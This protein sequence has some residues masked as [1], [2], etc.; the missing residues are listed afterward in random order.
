MAFKVTWLGHERFE[1]YTLTFEPG[2][3]RYFQSR[4]H[5]PN[6]ILMDHRFTHEA[7]PHDEAFP[8]ELVDDDD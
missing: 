4:E 8:P 5:I 1:G 6:E 2:Q 7:V 3:S